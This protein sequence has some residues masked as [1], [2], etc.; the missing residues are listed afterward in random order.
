MDLMTIDWEQIDNSVN[1]FTF[2]TETKLA[3]CVDVYDG[4]TIK[5]VFSLENKLYKCDCNYE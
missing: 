4:D 1:L 2:N 3:K 5:V